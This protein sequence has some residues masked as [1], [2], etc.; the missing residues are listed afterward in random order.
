MISKS[1]DD[2]KNENRP[3]FMYRSDELLEN[4]WPDASELYQLWDSKKA[5]RKAC[6][7][8]DLTPR[9][10]MK[11]LPLISIH[12][13]ATDPFR[14]KIRLMGTQFVDAIGMDLT[15]WFVDEVDK[16]QHVLER[17]QWVVSMC[18]PFVCIGLNLIWSPHDYKH[19]DSLVL[20]L[21]D[22]QGDV[23]MILYLNKFY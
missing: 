10:M 17:A 23:N 18:E 8:K 9:E 12:D 21:T 1:F 20:P 5:G 22:D 3:A 11:Q 19:Y 6:S 2:L 4:L 16:T 14:L 7:R 15:G 13:V